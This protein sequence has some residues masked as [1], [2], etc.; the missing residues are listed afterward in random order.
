[1]YGKFQLKFLGSPLKPL[2]EKNDISMN[3]N[4]KE[5]L[6]RI[7]IR[8]RSKDKEKIKQI[9]D[10]CGLRLSEYVVQRA[11]GYAPKAVQPDI[12]FHFYTKLCEVCNTA[13]I[14]LETESKLL[15]LI[16]EIH[17]ELLLPGREDIRNWQ[18]PDSGQSKT[19]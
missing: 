2:I 13:E 14:T 10:K 5:K 11:L 1:M 15:A 3:R 12:F 8:V 16:D 17:S 6:A 4:Q 18:P 9:A 7:E 19:G